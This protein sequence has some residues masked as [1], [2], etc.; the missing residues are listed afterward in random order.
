MED[1]KPQIYN[2]PENFIDESRIING[3][4]K[5]RNFIEASVMGIIH[6]LPSLFIPVSTFQTRVLLIVIFAIP[7]FCMGIAGFNGDPIS[8][9]A[10]NAYKW[11]KS[12]KIIL[13]NLNTRAL[14][15]N[16]LNAMMERP[17]PSDKILDAWEHFNMAKKEKI[18]Q[19]K[20]IEGETFEFAEDPELSKLYADNNINQTSTDKTKQNE[21][22]DVFEITVDDVI[23]PFEP[24]KI[25]LSNNKNSEL[26]PELSSKDIS[27]IIEKRGLF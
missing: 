26:A 18:A 7:A 17:Q 20:Y 24:E 5:T 16:P 21:F 10:I 4:F 13:Y 23:L 6:A 2:I 15:K 11:I 3:M 27:N 19:R 1:D 22:D 8:T 9:S 14:V 25:E 12:R